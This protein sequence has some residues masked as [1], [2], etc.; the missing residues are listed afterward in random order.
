M[1]RR[2]F[3]VLS[4]GCRERCQLPDGRE[5]YLEIHV[6]IAHDAPATLATQMVGAPEWFLAQLD[7]AAAPGPAR[8]L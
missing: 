3:A 4:A 7:F 1:C 6:R 5:P 8:K 2:P